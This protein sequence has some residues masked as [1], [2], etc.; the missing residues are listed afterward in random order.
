MLHTPSGSGPRPLPELPS[1][2]QLCGTRSS[3]TGPDLG[4]LSCCRA[5]ATSTSGCTLFNKK[6]IN[7][8]THTPPSQRACCLRGR[9]WTGHAAGVQ[10]PWPALTLL[11]ETGPQG[12]RVDPCPS[13]PQAPSTASPASCLALGSSGDDGG[14]GCTPCVP[15]VPLNCALNSGQDGKAHV[16]VFYH[17]KR[18]VT[19][20]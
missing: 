5:A 8:A 9:E 12:L 2:P 4:V 15:F 11:R 14:E 17:N 19:Y 3:P 1:N 7:L 18:C 10:G 20:V 13:G 16:C 6:D